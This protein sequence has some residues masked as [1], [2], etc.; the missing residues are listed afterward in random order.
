MRRIAGGLLVAVSG[1]IAAAGLTSCASRRCPPPP[2]VGMEKVWIPPRVERVMCYEKVP[3][4]TRDARVEDLALR[5]D[6]RKFTA[7]EPVYEKV[8][9]PDTTTALAPVCVPVRVPVMGYKEVEDREDCICPKYEKRCV[10]VERCKTRVTL[11][12]GLS[13]CQP[14]HFVYDC[15]RVRVTTTEEQAVKVGE[16]LGTRRVGSHLEQTP[17]GAKTVPMTVGADRVPCVTGSH[18]EERVAGYR[19]VTAKDD[20]GWRVAVRGEHT[21]KAVV[22]P[23][24]LRVVEKECVVPGFWAWV[25]DDPP[26]VRPANVLSRAEYEEYIRDSQLGVPR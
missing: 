16:T 18:V 8:L 17:V 23:G 24:E 12:L 2:P 7:Q 14:P 11:G 5:R 3:A 13:L 25:M 1:L 22:V 21:E 10:P 26:A 15:R 20:R 9:V 6:V 4:K 19:T